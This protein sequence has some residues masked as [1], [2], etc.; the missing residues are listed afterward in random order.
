[1]IRKLTHEILWIIEYVDDVNIMI[2]GKDGD[3][4]NMNTRIEC[5]YQD[6]M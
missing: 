4:K 6:R 3:I 2:I 1:V 5:E